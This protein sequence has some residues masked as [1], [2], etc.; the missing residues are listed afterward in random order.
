MYIS[1]IGMCGYAAAGEPGCA[2]SAQTQRLACEFDL[3]DD[4]FTTTAQCL[5][6][7]VEDEACFVDAE[8]E[9]DEGVEEC[10]DVLEARLELCESRDDATHD[11]GFGEAFAGNFVNPLEIGISIAPNPWFALV[12]DNTWVYEGDGE[13]IEVVVTGDTKLIDG[14][15]CVVV[16]DT[17]MEEGV[18]IEVTNDWY[19]QD[20][21][22]NVWYCGEISENFEEF[23]G[24]ETAEPELVDIDGSWKA[25][26]DGSEAGILLPFDPQPGD[27][28]RQE[29][30][31][32]DAEDAIE[33]MAID[34]TE[35]AP[36]G[37]CNGNCLLTRDF[38][39]LE[40][41][42]AENKYYVPGIGLIVEIDLETGDR[43]ELIE[44]TGVGL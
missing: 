14:V 31:Q 24:D 9:F 43:V 41:G 32:T 22:G 5:D 26:R 27:I 15:I 21:D 16:I 17:A 11:P 25:G 6:T 10:D 40:P 4:F 20:L 33:I 29:F 39:P 37:S 23:D 2:A 42:V 1:L 3:H 36:G 35:A 7:A 28:F 8:V 44:F 13:T 30:A 18:V 34:A 38:T 19:A 12:T